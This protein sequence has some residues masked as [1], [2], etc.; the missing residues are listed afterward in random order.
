[1]L[2]RVSFHVAIFSSCLLIYPLSTVRAELPPG[3]FL[4]LGALPNPTPYSIAYGISGDGSTVVGFSA[5]AGNWHAYR[6]T[7]VDGLNALNPSPP[8]N[9]YTVATGTSFDG[10]VVVGGY[11]DQNNDW[12]F[13]WTAEDGFMALHELT[14]ETFNSAAWDVSYDGRTVVGVVNTASAF[15]SGLPFVW[16]QDE[17]IQVLS[18]AGTGYTEG[19]PLRL[20]GDGSVAVGRLLRT[21]QGFGTLRYEA[22]YWSNDA[23]IVKLGGLHPLYIESVALGVSFDGSTIVGQVVRPQDNVAFRWTEPSG[24]QPLGD[25]PGGPSYSA[26][27]AVSADGSVIVGVGRTEIGGEAF[28]W[29]EVRGMRNLREILINQFGADLTGWQLYEPVDISADGRTIAGWGFN[30]EGRTEAWIA[31]IPEPQSAAL[32][33]VVSLVFVRRRWRR[34]SPC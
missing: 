15:D 6:W 34:S 21:E 29:D 16:R 17:G 10:S 5:H 22:F 25:L 4:G 12:S 7:A 3:S 18:L 30:P 14:P 20:S 19:V 33:G 2:P 27:T 28:V 8:A 31:V 1:M 26:A 23:G 13:R 24:M 32:V 9:S 11:G